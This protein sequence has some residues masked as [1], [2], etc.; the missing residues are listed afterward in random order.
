MLLF[1]KDD[2][3]QGLPY[4]TQLRCNADRLMLAVVGALLLLAFAL[5][6]WHDTWP[7]VLAI[8]L[9]T[10]ALAAWRVLAHPG[11]LLTRCVI[12]AA[13]M[14][15]TALHIHQARGMIELHFGVFVLLAFLLVYR[16]WIPI[17]VAATV[18]A[19][20]HL[21]FDWLQ[22]N[23]APIWT[24]AENT[25]FVIVL[26]HA[27]YV[28]FE[29]A[30]LVVIA[31]RLRAESEAIGSDPRELAQAALRIAA[32]Q[33]DSDVQHAGAADGS[34]AVAMN[35]MRHA[36]QETTDRASGALRG[37]ARGD[38]SQQLAQDGS[39]VGASVNAASE[40]LRAV[41][42]EVSSVLDGIAQG[43]LS[44]R[45]LVEAP[46]EFAR[47][48][49]HVNSTADFLARFNRSQSALIRAANAG[50]FSGRIDTNGLAGY[51]LELGAGIND[52]M[53]SFDAFVDQFGSIMSSFA[54]GDFEG[55]IDAVAAGRIEQLRRDT[56][57]TA[58]R[59]SQIVGRIR[60][61]AAEIHAAAESAA[62]SNS[63]LSTRSLQQSR[64]VE[65]TSSALEE[66]TSTVRHNTDRTRNADELARAT[67]QVAASG[68]SIV[69]DAVERMRGIRESSNRVSSIIEL[70]EG[71]AFQTNLLALNAA[72]EA[73]RAGEHGRGFAVVAIEV[74]SLAERSAA[75]AK[76]ISGL[77]QDSASRVE[78]GSELVNRAGSAMSQVTERVESIT[79]IVAEI[80]NASA[81]QSK[82]LESVASA[83][84]QIDGATKG[85]A[86][87]VS[88]ADDA[89][90]SLRRQADVLNEAIRL[91]STSSRQIATQPTAALSPT[92][93]AGAAA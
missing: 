29:T 90:G 1:M 9:P 36:L 70:I 16:D 35:R 92:G 34:L 12:A 86:G 30:L 4:L 60:D 89:A 64:A 26:V 33:L 77:I 23:G 67:A 59:L 21:V 79:G 2:V 82:A 6:P 50:D 56:N 48:R 22:R 15:F 84:N 69:G 41:V 7:E 51:Q 63:D 20:H 10:A 31:Q 71:I 85:I 11:S 54:R 42:R 74:R 40:T 72:V 5:A 93:A 13:L 81:E 52:L 68:R 75:A 53:Q 62:A 80:A 38:L 45:V 61:T 19:V 25:G 3:M 76:E 46:G 66:I 57:E 73:A 78:A 24:F 55:R 8:G 49:E 88:D 44:R 58:A 32:G 18:I 28:V 17:V 27:A 47:L 83:M 65:S 14:V 43:D 39:A 87:I 37:I 91:L